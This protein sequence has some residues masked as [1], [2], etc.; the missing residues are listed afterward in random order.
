MSRIQDEKKESFVNRV[1][2]ST[3]FLKIDPKAKLIY[4]VHRQ[5]AGTDAEFLGQNVDIKAQTSYI[6]HPTNT[7]ALEISTNNRSGCEMVGWFLN[8]TLETDAY[9]FVWIPNATMNGNEIKYINE[10]EV[11]VVDKKRLMDYVNTFHANDELMQIAD[12]MR[13]M[14]SARYPITNGMHLTLSESLAET[15]VNLVVNKSIL[16][17]FATYHRI[18]GAGLNIDLLVKKGEVA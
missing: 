8:P 1:L 18:V 5:C 6:N 13:T 14:H 7:F 11:M 3:F 10:M 4:D 9:A 17:R 15:P 12:E 2:L 16:K